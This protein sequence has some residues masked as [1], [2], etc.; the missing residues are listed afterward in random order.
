[1]KICII[2]KW[3]G[4]VKS[5][6]ILHGLSDGRYFFDR[7]TIL[8]NAVFPPLSFPFFYFILF[9]FI[10]KIIVCYHFRHSGE[11]VILLP[12]KKNKKCDPIFG[13]VAAPILRSLY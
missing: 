11:F 13:T 4:R 3:F 12:K 2:F 1:M 10:K 5:M 7:I 8:T 6:Y 9:F